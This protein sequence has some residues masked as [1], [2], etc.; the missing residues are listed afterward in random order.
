MAASSGTLP[1]PKNALARLARQ[2]PPSWTRRHAMVVTGW[3]P[4][5]VTACRRLFGVLLAGVRIWVGCWVWG[6]K[7]ER[8]PGI[9][10]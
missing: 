2:P 5:A 1:S 4:A 6:P 10:S 7:V 8:K 9:C 3:Y